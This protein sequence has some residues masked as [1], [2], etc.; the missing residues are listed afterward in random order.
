MNNGDLKKL[1][2]KWV[3]R[4]GKHV[5]VSK[6]VSKRIGSSM[7]DQLARG[8]YPRDLRGAS[9]TVIE[10]LLEKAGLLPSAKGGEPPR[11]S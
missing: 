11:A 8:D 5:V 1:L 7:A 2:T 4:D 3:S 6:L 10:D 9:Y